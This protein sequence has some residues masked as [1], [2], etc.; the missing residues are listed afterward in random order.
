MR[1]FHADTEGERILITDHPTVK[2]HL[3]AKGYKL[4][5]PSTAR[6]MT[7]NV[8]T[9]SMAKGYSYEVVNALWED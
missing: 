8:G 6:H 5:P 3:L 9:H 1:T 4:V 7:M 2:E